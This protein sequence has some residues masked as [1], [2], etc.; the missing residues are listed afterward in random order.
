MVKYI[1]SNTNFETT[2][3]GDEETKSELNIDNT[4]CCPLKSLLF[5]W[6]DVAYT[7]I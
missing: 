5:S 6:E 4:G 3:I 2:G 7:I 1:L